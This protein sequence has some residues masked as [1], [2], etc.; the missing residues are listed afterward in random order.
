MCSIQFLAHLINQRVAHQHVGVELLFLLLQN[1]TDHSVEVAIAFLKEVGAFLTEE[2]SKIMN[3]IFER[4]RAIL[5]EGEIDKR[6]QYMIETMF[7]IRKDKYKDHPTIP[8]GL[9]LVEEED[10]ITHL[11]S[12][13]DED[14]DPQDI[15]DVFSYDPSYLENEEQYRKIKAAILGDEGTTDA[16]GTSEGETTS[17]EESPS[18]VTEEDQDKNKEQI[19]DMTQSDLVHLRRTIYLTIMSS[20]DFEEVI[21]KLLKNTIQPGMEEELGNMIIECCSM[22]RSYLKFYGAMAQRLCELSQVYQKTFEKAFEYQYLMIH[23]LENNKLRNVTKLCAHLLHSDAIP[24]TVLECIH[25]NE[26]ETT[27]SSRIFIKILFQELAEHMGLVCLNDR[28]NDPFLKPYFAEIFPQDHPRK[29][30]FANLF[31]SSIGLGWLTEGLREFL[32]AAPLKIMEQRQSS[33]SDSTSSSS[34][35][36]SS[37]SSDS[38]SGADSDSDSDSTASTSSSA[39]TASSSSTS[40]DAQEVSSSPD[41]DT[42]TQ[43]SRGCRGSTTGRPRKYSPLYSKDTKNKYRSPE[44]PKR[45]ERIINATLTS[46]ERPKESSLSKYRINRKNSNDN[47]RFEK[48]SKPTSERYRRSTRKDT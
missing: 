10:Q 35:S 16:E 9:D 36:G 19:L 12:L 48:F 31:F 8:D 20:K 47:S 21:H 26:E 27:P 43:R 34:S 30:K 29:T 33:L 37:S 15:L 2:S 28:L 24:W 3:E 40:S 32:K 25:L 14:I 6:V 4:L 18:S 13:N 7:A 22:E 5:H 46:R 45:S 23:H 42:K 17:G 1:P 38:S 39:S 11:L 44:R 41:S